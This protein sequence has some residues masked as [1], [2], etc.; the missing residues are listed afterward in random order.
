MKFQFAFDPRDFEVSESE[1]RADLEYG[2]EP[3]HRDDRA[4]RASRPAPHP[5]LARSR[6]RATSRRTPNP[7]GPFP[8]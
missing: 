6:A 8:T 5:P 1:I 3:V 4:G 7:V 2:Q